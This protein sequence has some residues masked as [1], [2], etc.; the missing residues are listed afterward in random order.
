[1]DVE[2]GV[3]ADDSRPKQRHATSFHRRQPMLQKGSMGST[4]GGKCDIGRDRPGDSEGRIGEKLA[5]MHHNILSLHRDFS[6]V[7]P[8]TQRSV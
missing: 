5:T 6:M 1:V 3:A 4:L 2:L 8:G 7:S